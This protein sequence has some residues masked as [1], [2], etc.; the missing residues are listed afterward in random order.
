MND[1]KRATARRS[2]NRGGDAP[3]LAPVDPGTAPDGVVSLLKARKR[4]WG[5]A[6]NVVAEIAHAPAVLAMMDGV[7][8]NLEKSSLSKADRELIAME[9]AVQ[10]GCH[11]CVPAH[12]FV[13]AEQAGFDGETVEMLERVARGE[14]LPDES[15]LAALRKLVRRLIDT[16]GGLDD[17]EYTWFV[18]KGFPPQQMIEVIGE[19]AHCTVTNFTNRLARTP[20][21]GFLE[22]HR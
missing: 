13:A 14:A 4:K 11:Y 21:D 22:K 2:D 12:R 1:S 18:S 3:R 19:I 5:L 17:A 15:R 7:W 8:D 6:W 20:L 10:N 16:R 9:L